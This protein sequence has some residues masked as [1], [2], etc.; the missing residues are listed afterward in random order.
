[1]VNPGN[2]NWQGKSALFWAGTSA[3]FFVWTYFRLPETKDRSYEELNILFQEGVSARR[4]SKV[5]VDA[6]AE[7]S[8]RIKQE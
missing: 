6:Y 1:M 4:F 7:R 8:E 2:A 3:I 5:K